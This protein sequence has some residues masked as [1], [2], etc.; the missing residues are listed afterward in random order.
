MTRILS[1]V[2]LTCMAAVSLSGSGAAQ[3]HANVQREVTV[4]ELFAL[5]H[6]LELEAGTVV[7]WKDPHFERIW[8]PTSGPAVTRT[9]AGLTT[10]FD[11]PGEYRGRF[12]V[13]GG[14][15]GTSEIFP[16]TIVVR[17]LSP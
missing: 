7:V 12:T 14:I 13:V 1:L 8:F 6:R 9:P 4:Q 16:I 15:H 2:V 17:R 11:A 3:T 5:N 10:A